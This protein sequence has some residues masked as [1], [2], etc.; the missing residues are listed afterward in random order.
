MEV[1]YTNLWDPVENGNAGPCLKVRKFISP[2]HRPTTLTWGGQMTAH[3]VKALLCFRRCSVSRLGSGYE[4]LLI[5]QWHCQQVQ[6]WLPPCLAQ[7][8][9]GYVPNSKSLYTCVQIREGAVALQWKNMGFPFVWSNCHPGW[10]VSSHRAGTGR[11]SQAGSLDTREQKA[12]NREA[13]P[14]NV[15]RGWETVSFMSQSPNTPGNVP[16]YHQ[17]LLTRNKD[18]IIKNLNM[19]IIV[20]HIPKARPFLPGSEHCIGHIL[21]KAVSANFGNKAL[22]AVTEKSGFSL[23]VECLHVLWFLNYSYLRWSTMPPKV[24]LI[25]IIWVIVK[26]SNTFLIILLLSQRK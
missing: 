16:L 13:H 2:C 24:Q 7:E 22:L 3:T 25:L 12:S 26:N 20:F 17:D 8:K 21:V 14:N 4:I 5:V 6:G 19:A 9:A 23:N 1:Y 18:Q 15:Q 11:G 10:H